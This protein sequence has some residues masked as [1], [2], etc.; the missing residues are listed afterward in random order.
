[1]SSSQA[2]WWGRWRVG[3]GF[4][5]DS[6]HEPDCSSVMFRLSVVPE[7]EDAWVREFGSSDEK[8]RT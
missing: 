5:K 3:T 6:R 7:V 8:C 1:M 4:I 2:G